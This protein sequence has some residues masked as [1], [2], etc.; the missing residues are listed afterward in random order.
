[1]D[2]EKYINFKTTEDFILDKEFVFWILHP[3]NETRQV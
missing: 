1:M 2:P 3:E